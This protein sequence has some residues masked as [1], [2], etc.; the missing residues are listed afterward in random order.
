[1]AET[2]EVMSNYSTL[3][4][5]EDDASYEN[6]QLDIAANITVGNHT[7]SAN[8]LSLNTDSFDS[9]NENES[10]VSSFSKFS[11]EDIDLENPF[12]QR[13]FVN[14]IIGKFES[15]EE[16]ISVLTNDKKL[17][18]N[19]ILNI[20]YDN[21]MLADHN[22]TLED[23]MYKMDCKVIQIDQYS[24]RSNLIIS[25]IPNTVNHHNLENKV[26]EILHYIGMQVS[27]YEIV[28]CH[29]LGKNNGKFPPQTIVRFTNRKLVEF[30]FKNKDRLAKY[31]KNNGINIK[32]FVNMCNEN[33]I[34]YKD[35]NNMKYQGAIYDFYVR[36]G[37]IKVII[38]QGDKPVL[39]RHPDDLY[40]LFHEYYS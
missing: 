35:C 14:L 7:N 27:S 26:L 18:S 3:Y 2:S 21:K 15:L 37:F 8:P 28:A 6:H 29:R 34:I 40:D 4:E 30:C 32:F 13:S 38:K 25:G 33:N 16:K 1:M 36:N 10:S 31:K 23:I 9:E 11:G 24:R 17:L 22:S 5:R 20:E 12:T 19:R 39:I